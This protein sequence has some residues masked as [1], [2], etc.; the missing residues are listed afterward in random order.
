[1]KKLMTVIV[2]ALCAAGA[3]SLFAAATTVAELKEALAKATDDAVIEVA[4]GTF[5]ISE[6]LTL[7]G[8][9]G[10]TLKG[11]GKALTVFTP[12]KDEGGAA[13]DTR[14]LHVT[15]C[16]GFTLQGI[17]FR[18][19]RRTVAAEGGAVRIENTEKAALNLA[20]CAFIDNRIDAATGAA[21][22]A[23]L[24]TYNCGFSADGCT[25]LSNVCNS[26]ASTA[27]GGGWRNEGTT[28]PLRMKDC[29][30]AYNAVIGQQ[31]ASGGAFGTVSYASDLF[32]NCLVVCNFAHAPIWTS[33]RKCGSVGGFDNIGGNLY[34]CTFAH[35]T[36]P[37][38][39][40]PGSGC[41][42]IYYR[43]CILWGQNGYSTTDTRHQ[44]NTLTDFTG[45]S[46]S[47][48][49][50]PN[51][52][53]KFVNGYH[54]ASDSPA[55]DA[56]KE[57]S[58][59]L[60]LD[61]KTVFA[62]GELDTGTV[63]LG[64]HY[65]EG[66]DLTAQTL[67]V[68]SAAAAEGDGTEGAPYK[69]LTEALRHATNDTIIRLAS[70]TY[71]RASG[72][73]FP[74]APRDVLQL[75]IVCD[76]E[77]PAVF[78]NG[79]VAGARVFDV[80]RCHGLVMSNLVMTGGS[81][82]SEDE[83]GGRAEGG[84]LR[85]LFSYDVRLFDVLVEGNKAEVTSA[86]T[87]SA[88]GGGAS[89]RSSSVTAR[90]MS[91]S[92]NRVVGNKANGV[93]GGLIYQDSWVKIDNAWVTNNVAERTTGAGG[94]AAGIYS[95][96]PLSG[97]CTL[98]NL[99]VSGNSCNNS[100]FV[101]ACGNLTMQ[102]STV[103]GND[104]NGWGRATDAV[105]TI[106]NSIW[107]QNKETTIS[108]STGSSANNILPQDGD[109][110]FTSGFYL[111]EGSP[112]IDSG[113]HADLAAAGLEDWL[114]TRVDG[115]PD[116]GVPDRGFHYPTG[117]DVK[118]YTY[119]VD[120][121]KGDDTATGLDEDHPLKTLTA[122]MA[123]AGN[124]DTVALA[125]GT[126][127]VASGETFPIAFA[128]L[129]DVKIVVTNAPSA[130]LDATGSGRRVLTVENAVRATFRNLVFTGGV[131]SNDSIV[132]TGEFPVN[133]GGGV[134]VKGGAAVAFEGC[135]ITDNL[136]TVVSNAYKGVVAGG[137]VLAQGADVTFTG[138]VVDGNRVIGTTTDASTSGK[139]GSCGGGIAVLSSNF[140]FN[141]GR[142]SGNSVSGKGNSVYAQKGAGVYVGHG[143]FQTRNSLYAKNT[144]TTLFYSCY[145]PNGSEKFTYTAG[146][147]N[148]YFCTFAENGSAAIAT[149]EGYY[150]QKFYSCAL[151]GNGRSETYPDGAP[152]TDKR[153]YWNNCLLPVSSTGLEQT[154]GCI[155]TN[156][157]GIVVNR[158]TGVCKVR[159]SSPVVDA[160]RNTYP[161]LK[162]EGA[163]DNNGN[164]RIVG[165]KD[166]KTPVAD[167]G[168]V[169]VQCIPGLLLMVW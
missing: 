97:S 135:R 70:G 56:G 41:G 152:E 155:L 130:T 145:D 68:D 112:A 3:G 146:K 169:E 128:G 79:G 61:Q 160:S 120:P 108:F 98:R 133:G 158:A 36:S 66:I 134:L 64:Y 71:D 161:W 30:F 122:A 106:C 86:E 46:D 149:R 107:S 34:N 84:G 32:T 85:L 47:Y 1:M 143:T 19:A 167:I 110:K 90:R 94:T 24:Y 141:D 77:T 4:A 50:Y 157:A 10:V 2:S 127:S 78:D 28:G 118:T 63:D 102:Y 150:A 136:A 99:L 43:N 53:P 7:T 51:V 93:G 8:K 62:D 101:G 33:A 153:P 52:D 40:R 31:G 6:E 35:N 104:C 73:T 76:G 60:G 121:V 166:K 81:A 117:L 115:T 123:K 16:P 54:L 44:Y 83:I 72:E 165:I 88:F 69:T 137:G 131:A 26:A 37:A 138:C 67:Y 18:G 23:G 82:V 57:T 132:A 59:K 168:C 42:E 147:I 140:T 139:S 55:R 25:F 91:F 74:I 148:A 13:L 15:D 129:E 27:Y 125:G 80:V 39:Q 14:L 22:G 92:A 95:M 21:K 75:S 162:A 11:A 116:T 154:N 17:T 45:T 89:V 113:N 87:A 65:T 159:S 58:A 156:K 163:L 142:I 126:Y 100:A 105:T 144:G 151:S 48:T 12:A 49:Y 103:A 164:P 20:D 96:A 29:V 114:V 119:L 111:Q 124:G 5:D 9:S 38:I 109:P